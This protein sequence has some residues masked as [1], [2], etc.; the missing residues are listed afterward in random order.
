CLDPAAL[1]VPIAAAEGVR[2]TVARAI[3]SICGSVQA[4][5][6]ASEAPSP[7]PRAAS[8][9]EAADALDKALK[10]MSD[11]SGPPEDEDE[12]RRVTSTLHALDHATRLAET[13][14]GETAVPKT[15]APPSSARRR[16]RMQP[17]SRARSQLSRR[18]S[19]ARARSRCGATRRTRL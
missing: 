11:V 13:A 10:F 14:G 8:V 15:R 4:A 19:R 3:G 2:R 17:P 12:Q 9:T 18:T 5:L 1:A 16:C 6:K 7:V